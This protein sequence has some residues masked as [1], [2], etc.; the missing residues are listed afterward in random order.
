M[1]LSPGEGISGL[2]SLKVSMAT[3]IITNYRI[4]NLN[5][6]METLMLPSNVNKSIFAVTL[7]SVCV[8]FGKVPQMIKEE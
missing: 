1:N 8:I 5:L 2:A 6:P 4:D 7:K 3:G